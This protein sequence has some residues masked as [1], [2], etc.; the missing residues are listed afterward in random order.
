MITPKKRLL[1]IAAEISAL[2]YAKIRVPSWDPAQETLDAQINAL[3][4]Q[5][6]LKMIEKM[7]TDL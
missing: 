6:D 2:L 7:K 4:Q 3:L 1:E 5:F